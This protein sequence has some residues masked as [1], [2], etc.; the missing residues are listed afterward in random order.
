[1]SM[2]DP[3]SLYRLAVLEIAARH[4]A[5]RRDALARSCSQRSA[6]T[7]RWSTALWERL[8]LL[9]RYR[10]RTAQERTMVRVACPTCC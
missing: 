7:W 6:A 5:A 1:M 2:S 8:V 3:E 4:A 10:Y 9:R